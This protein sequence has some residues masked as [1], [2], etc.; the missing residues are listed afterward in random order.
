MKLG[1]GVDLLL[2]AGVYMGFTILCGD[3]QRMAD[4][5][6]EF[7]LICINKH[8]KQC[9]ACRSRPSRDMHIVPK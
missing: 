1:I 5:K 7:F 8:G 9:G 2:A 6:Q 4:L 3:L